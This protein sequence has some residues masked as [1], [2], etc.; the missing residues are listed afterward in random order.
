M[1]ALSYLLGVS[2]HYGSAPVLGLFYVKLKKVWTYVAI[3]VGLFIANKFLDQDLLNTRYGDVD[4]A[5]QFSGGL[6]LLLFVGVLTFTYKKIVGKSLRNQDIILLYVL[7]IGVFFQSSFIR[8]FLMF[9][10]L[11]IFKILMIVDDS[12]IKQ[13]KRMVLLIY[14]SLSFLFEL[15]E[16]LRTAHI[17]G[18][19]IWFP[20]DNWL[21]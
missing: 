13:S 4:T 10:N 18:T 20:Y 15:Y 7:L 3:L 12:V 2:S 16:I 9:S 8:M 6:R 21:F 11:L 19:G 17:S 14:P 5:Y 1:V